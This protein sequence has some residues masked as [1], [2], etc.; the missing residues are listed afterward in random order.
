VTAS[1]KLGRAIVRNRVKRRIREWFRCFR[2]EFEEGV[3]IVVIARPGAATL[4][5]R[6]V[7]EQLRKLGQRAGSARRRRSA[8]CGG[9]AHG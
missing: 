8:E 2:E 6:E 3:D 4:A 1:R 5:G 7:C 9:E